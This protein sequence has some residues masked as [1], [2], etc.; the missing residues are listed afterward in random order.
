MLPLDLGLGI[1]R[2]LIGLLFAGHGARKLL[3]WF[4]GSGLNGTAGWVEGL[5]FRPGRPWAL[6]LGLGE[7]LGGLLLALGLAT[8][9]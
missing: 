8:P 3:G 4:G 2:V 6:A 1:L 7:L 5:G 9:V